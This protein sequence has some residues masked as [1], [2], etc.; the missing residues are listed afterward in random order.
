LR[1]F[2]KISHVVEK[3][4][5]GQKGGTRYGEKEMRGK[6]GKGAGGPLP[7]GETT[8]TKKKKAR[9]FFPPRTEG[10]KK[11]RPTDSRTSRKGEKG[12]R[13]RRRRIMTG[14]MLNMPG[15]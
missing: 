11:K 12:N 5:T 3:K 14:K 4:T 8:L 15:E 7:A 2:P 1:G 10:G 6:T 9:S 13:Q